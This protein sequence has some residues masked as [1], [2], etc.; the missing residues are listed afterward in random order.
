[1]CSHLSIPPATGDDLAHHDPIT[2]SVRSG[3]HDL[4]VKGLDSESHPSG[5]QIQ[6]D[7]GSLCYPDPG[8]YRPGRH[9]KFSISWRGQHRLGFQPISQI[10]GQ[11]R[12]VQTWTYRVI[13]RAAPIVAAVP[14]RLGLWR[15]RS[16]PSWWSGQHGALGGHS[17]LPILIESTDFGSFSAPPLLP[18][19]CSP[20]CEGI[21][22]SL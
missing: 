8:R 20:P 2:Q 10:W 3:F 16:C 9:G 21:G 17:R 12:C 4:A 11:Q 7:P 15:Y 14:R 6:S 19:S 13:T 22:I 5:P 1:M 18:E